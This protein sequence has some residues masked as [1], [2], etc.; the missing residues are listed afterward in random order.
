LASINSCNVSDKIAD[1]ATA[2]EIEAMVVALR[3]RLREYEALDDVSGDAKRR[4]VK[5]ALRVIRKGKVPFGWDE[6]YGAAD[7]LAPILT[8]FDAAFE[9]AYQGRRA[10]HAGRG[11]SS[12]P[13]GSRRR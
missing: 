6:R 2:Q 11:W 5:R 13:R 8:Q 3:K 10:D 12:R 7:I 9:K 1:Y 4:S